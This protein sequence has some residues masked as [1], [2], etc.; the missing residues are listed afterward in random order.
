MSLIL[1]TLKLV[2]GILFIALRFFFNFQTTRH[3]QL[4]L[5]SKSPV[6]ET[7]NLNMVKPFKLIDKMSDNR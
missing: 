2:R 6:R 1:Y 3:R 5:V 7:Q 4:V